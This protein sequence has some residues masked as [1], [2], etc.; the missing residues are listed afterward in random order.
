MRYTAEILPYHDYDFETSIKELAG[1]GFKEVNLWSSA[2]PLAHHVNPGDD[3][4]KI[5]AVLDKYKMK[6]CG[7]TMYGKNQ[8]EML[9]RIDFAVRYAQQYLCSNRYDTGRRSCIMDDRFQ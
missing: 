6:P 5:L 3:P 9:E 4:K 2:K 7:L 8:Q 1:L